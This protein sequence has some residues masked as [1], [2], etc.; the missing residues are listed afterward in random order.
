MRT[1]DIHCIINIANHFMIK[2]NEN[3]YENK[4]QLFS[5]NYTSFNKI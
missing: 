3:F 5:I 1:Y 4:N 2:K